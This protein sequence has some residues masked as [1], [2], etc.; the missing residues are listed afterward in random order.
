MLG[1]KEPSE[2]LLEALIQSGYDMN[3]LNFSIRQK[4][5]A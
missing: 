2:T 3:T 1:P 4:D 5:A